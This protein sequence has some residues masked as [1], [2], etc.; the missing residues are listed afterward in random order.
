MLVYSL[1]RKARYSGLQKSSTEYRAW[2][3]S[4]PGGA[5]PL[6]QQRLCFSRRMT[7]LCS[8]L[9]GFRAG[10]GISDRLKVLYKYFNF[11]QCI[12]ELPSGIVPEEVGNHLT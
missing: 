4:S 9:T 6:H 7:P 8:S 5:L 2:R 11:V 10:R 12:L 3:R 1:H